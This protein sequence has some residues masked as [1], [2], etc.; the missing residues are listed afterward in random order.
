MDEAERRGRSETEM[1]GIRPAQR[2]MERE[3][4]RWREQEEER[5][6]EGE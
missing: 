6:R 3:R 5:R 2:G 4:E 1:D